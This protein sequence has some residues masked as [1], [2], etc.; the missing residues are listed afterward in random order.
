MSE[1]YKS[2]LRTTR[3]RFIAVWM[4]SVLL[5]GAILYETMVWPFPANLPFLF[6]VPGSVILSVA[7][8]MLAWRWPRLGEEKP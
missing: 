7:L 1:S 6:F 5:L 3:L 8:G 2:V 4:A